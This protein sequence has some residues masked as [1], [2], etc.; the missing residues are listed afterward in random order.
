MEISIFMD[1]ELFAELDDVGLEFME[2]FVKLME[3]F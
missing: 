2:F 1:I 3:I